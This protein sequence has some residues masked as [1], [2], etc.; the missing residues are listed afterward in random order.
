[1][2]ALWI[3]LKGPILA[4]TVYIDG[5]LVAKDVSITLP[6]VTLVT[7]DFKAMGT[8]T[9]PLTGQIEAMEASITKI[10]VDYGLRNMV[11]FQ[12]KTVEIRWAQDVKYADGSSKTE[13]CKA[14][15]RCVPKQIPGL[16]VEPGSLSENEITLAVSRYQLFVAGTE[17]WLIDQLNTIMRVNGVDY[18][19]TLRSVL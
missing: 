15:L 2:A 5:V 4:D 19:K 10:G 6:A 1:M 12:S 18:V 13:G 17:Y 8:Y 14:F 16:S 3:D 11:A 7:A 9:A